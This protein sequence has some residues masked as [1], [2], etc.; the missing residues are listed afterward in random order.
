LRL[1]FSQSSHDGAK[2]SP[3]HRLQASSLGSAVALEFH[4]RGLKVIATA[5][6]LSNLAHLTSLD[7]ETYE[8]DVTSSASVAVLRYKIPHLD[9][10]FNS[11]GRSPVGAFADTDMVALHREFKTNVFGPWELI[12]AFL[13]LLLESEGVIVN[14][15]SQMALLGAPWTAAFNASKAALL[16]TSDSM[17]AEL[18]PFGVRVLYVATTLASSSALEGMI[19]H[20]RISEG[21]MYKSYE[22]VLIKSFVGAQKMCIGGGVGQKRRT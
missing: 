12:Q 3:H 6:T 10:L 14:H 16:A 9:I 7:I 22:A 18:A 5:H 13:P 20:A 11:A 2:D 15:G 17:R 8:L 4:A 21:S 19:Q 1:L